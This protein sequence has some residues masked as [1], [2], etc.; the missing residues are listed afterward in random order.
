VHQAAVDLTALFVL[1]FAE[2]DLGLAAEILGES[3][4]ARRFLDA[5]A[6]H[7]PSALPR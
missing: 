7:S 4:L 5:S 1:P 6:A 2:R 3:D